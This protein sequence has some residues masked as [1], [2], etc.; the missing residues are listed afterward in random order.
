MS[1]I[2][3]QTFIEKTKDFSIEETLAFLVNEYNNKVVFFMF[4]ISFML[5]NKFN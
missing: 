5:Y 2:K 1:S 4:V 3:V